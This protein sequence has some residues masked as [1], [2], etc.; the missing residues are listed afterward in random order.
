MIEYSPVDDTRSEQ[1]GKDM[2]VGTGMVG[3]IGQGST[4]VEWGCE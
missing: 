3:P 1:R 4:L 2:F